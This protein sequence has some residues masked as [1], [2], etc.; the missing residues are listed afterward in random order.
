M[1]KKNFK[2]PLNIQLFAEDGNNGGQGATDT[3]TYSKEEY[4]K[5]KASFDKTSS[6]LANLKKEARA[7][8]SEEEK[9]QKEQE[10]KDTRLKELEIKVLT[11]DMT[12][13]LMSSGLEKSSIS[14]IV[15]A[16]KKGDMVNMAKVIATEISKQIEVVKKQAEENFQKSGTTPPAGDGKKQSDGFVQSLLAKKNTSSSQNARDYYMGKK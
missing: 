6:E 16:Y 2:F 12:N 7:K 14:N 10:E 5:L 11:S 1:E 15:E 9:R 3:T 13:E 8:L 4:D